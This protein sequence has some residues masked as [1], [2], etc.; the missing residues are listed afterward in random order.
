[1]DKKLPDWKN[2]GYVRNLGRGENK[3]II[4]NDINCN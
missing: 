4:K 3:T 1:V 2:T